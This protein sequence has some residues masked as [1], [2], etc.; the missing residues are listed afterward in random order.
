MEFHDQQNNVSELKNA[1]TTQIPRPGI[2][3]PTHAS[4]LASLTFLTIRM[5]E[6]FCLIMSTDIDTFLFYLHISSFLIERNILCFPVLL[7][8]VVALIDFNPA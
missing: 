4:G 1:V 2:D 5:R 6:I 8:I 7:L 3:H